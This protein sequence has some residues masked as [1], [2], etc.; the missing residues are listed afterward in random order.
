[1][2]GAVRARHTDVQRIET[3]LVEIANLFQ[4]MAQLVEVQE[5]LAAEID[6]NAQKTAQDVEKAVTEIKK[7]GDHARRIRKLKWWT[8]GIFLTIVIL[9]A[10][11][12]GV[13]FYEMHLMN[14]RLA[15]AAKKTA[16][17]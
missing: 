13:Y 1:M 10:I 16:G 2:L 11:A 6:D 17:P 14:Q 4:D 8:L 7:A 15:S 5:P 3:T 9:L 12:L